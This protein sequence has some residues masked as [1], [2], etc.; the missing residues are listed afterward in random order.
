MNG[1]IKVQVLLDFLSEACRNKLCSR[2]P[3]R[4]AVP[5]TPSEAVSWSER[6]TMALHHR[7]YSNCAVGRP[8][9][10]A[11]LHPQ[12]R[13]LAKANPFFFKLRCRP[14]NFSSA[15]FTYEVRVWAD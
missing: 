12:L 14:D 7:G 10:R 3:S 5:M 15:R 9:E 2:V 11:V 4:D 6:R 8:T 1:I 13:K